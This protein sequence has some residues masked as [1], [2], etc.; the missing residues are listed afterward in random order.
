[1]EGR[2][3]GRGRG[4]GRFKKREGGYQDREEKKVIWVPKTQLGRDVLAGKVKSFDEILDKGIK[5]MEPQIVDYFFPQ[6]A[7]DFVMIGQSKGKFG[8]GSRRVYK[9]TQKKVREGART[10][11]SYIAVVGNNDGY[12]GLGKG[13][14]RESLPAK[15]SATK[16]AK[17][18]LVRILRACGSWEC[19]CGKPHSVPFKIRGK[20]SSVAVELIPAPRGTGLVAHPE[21]KRILALAGITD[22][23]SRMSGETRNRINLG[24]AT[25]AALKQTSTLSVP[26]E[27]AEK[28]GLK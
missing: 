24:Y 3:G 1:M 23:W 21:A 7:I 4:R 18:N 10:K 15:E 20:S 22:A 28:W 19:G 2:G 5:V 12:L 11:F 17:L 6:L 9:N 13:S 26:K 8:G 16:A 25:F 14:S 27:F